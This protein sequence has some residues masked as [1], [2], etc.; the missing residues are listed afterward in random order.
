MDRIP[1][2]EARLYQGMLIRCQRYRGDY[3]CSFGGATMLDG[4]GMSSST[5]VLIVRC[6]WVSVVLSYQA[7]HSMPLSPKDLALVAL[8]VMKARVW[9]L[10]YRVCSRPGYEAG[11]RWANRW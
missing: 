3:V 1:R 10:G 4:D 8:P 7:R 6:T 5:Q 11:L 9:L 2:G